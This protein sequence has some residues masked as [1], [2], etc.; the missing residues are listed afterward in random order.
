[1]LLAPGVRHAGCFDTE[2]PR[3]ARTAACRVTVKPI[4]KDQIMMKRFLS[5]T[6]L[7]AMTATLAACPGDANDDVVVQDTGLVTGFDTIQAP[8][9]VPTTDT[10]VETTTIE[11]DTIAGGVDTAATRP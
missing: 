7:V 5:L 11:V 10:V 3:R 8:V 6:A 4:N 2:R 9:Q 1:M